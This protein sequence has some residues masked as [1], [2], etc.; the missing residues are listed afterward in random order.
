MSQS[1]F[2]QLP[3]SLSFSDPQTFFGVVE[4][5]L[6]AKVK[7]SS[8]RWRNVRKGL[9][10]FNIWKFNTQKVGVVDEQTSQ[11]NRHGSLIFVVSQTFDEMKRFCYFQCRYFFYTPI[12]SFSEVTSPC[13]NPVYP[14]LSQVNCSVLSFA[15]IRN[16]YFAVLCCGCL[17]TIP[18]L[19]L[20]KEKNILF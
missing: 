6:Q 16:R 9:K 11:P 10:Y 19:Q 17:L 18:E 14:F 8:L 2:V 4:S 15:G 3:K 12:S 5:W 7:Q 1:F 13:R 20:R